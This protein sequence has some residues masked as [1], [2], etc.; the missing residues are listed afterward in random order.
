MLTTTYALISLSVEQKRAHKLLSTVQQLFQNSSADRQRTNPAILESVVSQ[1]ARLD[2]SC[3][4]RK[5]EIYVIPA[6]QKA[7]KEADSL[8]AE[9][10]S[11]SA[12]GLRILES[13]RKWVRQA[14]DQGVTEVKELY[15]SIELYCNNLLQRLVK[16]EQE[17][18][19]LAERVISS[20]E[21]FAIGAQFLS[22]YAENKTHQ[23]S[24]GTVRQR[25]LASIPVFSSFYQPE[26]LDLRFS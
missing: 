16:E 14:F 21:W 6:I 11:L 8:L 26:K 12:T 5:V 13:V 19:P 7:T 9:L 15:S 25:P 10:E 20:E 18:L 1:L 23:Q 22:L 24:E 2:A 3:H 4:R 17:L